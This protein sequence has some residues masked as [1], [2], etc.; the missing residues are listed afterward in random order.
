[1]S[2]GEVRRNVGEF[3]SDR[4]VD[5]ED[6]I[7]KAIPFL[8]GRRRN[9]SDPTGDAT[10]HE[11]R[12]HFTEKAE[13]LRFVTSGEVL[14]GFRRI[15][16]LFRRSSVELPIG[17]AQT[18]LDILYSP[19]E[20][21]RQ[22]ANW[23]KDSLDNLQG[24]IV[25]YF[26]K[27]G[28]DIREVQRH[29]V[30]LPQQR[31]FELYMKGESPGALIAPWFQIPNRRDPKDLEAVVANDIRITW[32]ITRYALSRGA[33]IET[34]TLECWWAALQ[35]HD[36]VY[37][38]T[39][40]YLRELAEL[41]YAYAER[42]IKFW[43]GLIYA[44]CLAR[45]RDE[46]KK[47]VIEKELGGLA[48]STGIFE[49]CAFIPLRD[50]KKAGRLSVD[51]L[52]AIVL[53]PTTQYEVNM[54]RAVR[55]IAACPMATGV[56]MAMYHHHLWTGDRLSAENMPAM[57]DDVM[58]DPLLHEHF[59]VPRAPDYDV[60]IPLS[61][62]RHVIALE[63]IGPAVAE[64]LATDPA[65]REDHCR[66]AL[67]VLRRFHHLMTE[68][69]VFVKGTAYAAPQVDDFKHKSVI[70]PLNYEQLIRR[71]VE[72]S[73]C[74]RLGGGNAFEKLIPDVQRIGAFLDI[75]C[76]G[77]IVV[78]T[79]DS[80][81]GNR[82][83]DLEKVALGNWMYD[84][85]RFLYGPSWTAKD[86]VNRAA[87]RDEYITNFQREVVRTEFIPSPL[88]TNLTLGALSHMFSHWEDRHE[89]VAFSKPIWEKETRKRYGNDYN[90]D[91]VEAVSSLT[92][93]TSLLAWSCVRS[94]AAHYMV[95]ACQAA[96][97][98]ALMGEVGALSHQ[99]QVSGQGAL[100]CQPMSAELEIAVQNSHA[101]MKY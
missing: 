28:E 49:G 70:P 60:I 69:L 89:F 30:L 2:S 26:A 100:D 27:L 56:R 55:T 83:I 19:E 65:R 68:N 80:N 1:M 47:S 25:R 78:D 96:A 18:A 62:G 35:Q 33:A 101:F 21:A 73:G 38:Q 74:L 45:E 58:T 53:K 15:Q 64:M 23:G 10:E 31:A 48:E 51:G 50:G 37:A 82:I 92:T 8:R 63:N 46:E 90:D 59:D 5:L 97:I 94:Y 12:A 4:D 67:D 61:G 88:L 95:H 34:N 36:P 87:L 7:N 99:L 84:V 16:C 86:G 17:L 14:E 3:H 24:E 13:S 40:D 39:K 52:A 57:I 9:P 66:R 79:D 6:R 54:V 32:G 91:I 93:N 77:V 22:R 43:W 71:R 41:R 42:E 20:A 81:I 76:V 75:A 85:A 98:L 72:G 29:L 44:I 11:I